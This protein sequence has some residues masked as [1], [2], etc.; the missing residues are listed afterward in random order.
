MNE[1]KLMKPSKEYA[2]DIMKF[3]KELLDAGSGFAGYG[4]LY[5]CT[6]ADEW[7]D[8][9]RNNEKTCQ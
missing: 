6:T 8:I 1:I 4:S 7:V 2:N 5:N 9:V 3:R